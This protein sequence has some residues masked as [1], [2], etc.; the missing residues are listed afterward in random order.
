MPRLSLTARLLGGF[1]LVIALLIT[2]ATVAAVTGRQAA[3]RLHFISDGWIPSLAAV[4]DMR[5]ALANYRRQEFAHILAATPASM[6]DY[7]KLATQAWNEFADAEGRYEALFT[8][9]PPTDEERAAH[10]RM[11]ESL[12]PYRESSLALFAKSRAGQ[13]EEAAG[14]MRGEHRT[15]YYE[16][17]NQLDT[18]NR[19]NHEGAKQARTEAEAAHATGMTVIATVA[20]AGT[21]L[22]LLIA[23]L[24]ARSVTVPL[25]RIR[26]VL[27]RIAD[28]DL[29][30]RTGLVRRDEIGELARDLDRTA[31]TLRQVV[32][33]IRHAADQAAASGEELSAS[34]QNISQGAQTQSGEVERI[35]G[36]M[37]RLATA[38]G[39]VKAAADAA[40]AVAQSNLASAERGGQAVQRSS[41]GMRLISDSSAKI[42]KIS[43]VIVQIANQTNLLALN[44]AIEAASAGE[45]GL[46]FAVVADEVRKLAERAS[47]AA[48]EITDLIAQSGER[49]REG[50]QVTRE[51]GSVL[52]GIAEGVRSAATAMAEIR[53]ATEA[54]ATTAGEVARSLEGVAAITEENSGSAEEMAAAAEE[55]SAQAQHLQQLVARFQV[56]GEAAAA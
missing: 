13:D 1:A 39:G 51:V 22:S 20:V 15:R 34:A 53:G 52:G 38:V 47:T 41:D 24:I 11:Q 45:H 40:A 23:L 5:L 31:D 29:T 37:Q 44:A 14:M 33:E 49:V 4:A 8:L 55:L 18:I 35:S 25:A 7:E 6:D 10:T 43:G 32:G 50:E 30:V 54:Q 12:K 26:G 27:G 9:A 17:L 56:D 2:T 48:A 46:G 16:V 19:I 28:G 21:V 36:S 42:A 3:E